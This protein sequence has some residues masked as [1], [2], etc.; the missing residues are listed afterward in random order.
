MIPIIKVVCIKGS[1]R[2]PTT[3]QE[4]RDVRRHTTKYIPLVVGEIYDAYNVTN[5]S[6]MV[7]DFWEHKSDFITLEEYRTQKLDQIINY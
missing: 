4:L 1:S 6:Y 7:N 3:Q 2:L 5:N